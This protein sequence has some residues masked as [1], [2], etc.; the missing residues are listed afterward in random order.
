MRMES[1]DHTLQTTALINEAHL[2]L[3]D[4]YRVN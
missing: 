2:K 1:P 3:V 4:Q